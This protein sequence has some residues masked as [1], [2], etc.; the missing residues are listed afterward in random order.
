MMIVLISEANPMKGVPEINKN[1]QTVAGMAASMAGL[2]AHGK[3]SE[4]KMADALATDAAAPPKRLDIHESAKDG[5]QKKARCR[6]PYGGR[7]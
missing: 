2:A 1:Q 3:C 5:G 7:S 4:K 6:T